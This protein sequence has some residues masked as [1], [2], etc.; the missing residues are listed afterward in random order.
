[1]FWS[2]HTQKTRYCYCCCCCCCCCCWW[3]W[4]LFLLLL[5]LVVVVVV[6]VVVAELQGWNC[7]LCSVSLPKLGPAQKVKSLRHHFA[8]KHKKRDTSLTWGSH[9]SKNCQI[10][11]RSQ[12]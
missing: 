4:W 9:Q 11:Q 1:M 6:V 3:W 12:V 10:Q 7:P 5:L 2:P 8:T